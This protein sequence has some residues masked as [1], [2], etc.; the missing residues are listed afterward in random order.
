MDVETRLYYAVKEEMERRGHRLAKSQFSYDPFFALVHAVMRDPQ[1]GLLFRRGGPPGS[2]WV[3]GGPVER[4][5]AASG[6]G[7]GW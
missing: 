1:T 3:R 4:V 7:S 6:P 5:F 2:W